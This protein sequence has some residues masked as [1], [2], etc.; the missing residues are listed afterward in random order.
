MMNGKAIHTPYDGI[1]SRSVQNKEISI[2]IYD[3]S[4]FGVYYLIH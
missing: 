2:H 1:I 3:F 4:D